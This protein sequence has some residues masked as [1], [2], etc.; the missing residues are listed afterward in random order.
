MNCNLF[1]KMKPYLI[2][3]IGLFLK[4]IFPC[5]P[6]ILCGMFLGII[7][8]CILITASPWIQNTV[9]ANAFNVHKQT[10]GPNQRFPAANEERRSI[11]DYFYDPSKP[12]MIVNTSDNIF[13]LKSHNTV[14]R[15]G[16]CSTGSYTL[17]KSGDRRE[18]IFQTPRGRFIIQSKVTAP[19]WHMPDWAFIE[20]GKAVPPPGSPD[21]IQEGVLGDYALHFGNGYMIHGTLYQRFLGLPV[22][23]GCIRLC[24][25]D[26]KSV[27][28]TLEVG[29]YVFVY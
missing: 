1:N 8:S 4:R 3:F 13:I 20:E 26:L 10:I 2:K 23:H 7:L 28:N 24:D 16:K 6:G 25:D 22:T 11:N 17:L 29:S 12:Y 21:R 9:I 15:T 19:V 18:W 5:L 14:L 27:Y